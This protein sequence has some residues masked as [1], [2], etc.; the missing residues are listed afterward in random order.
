MI[1]LERLLDL[2]WPPIVFDQVL[3]YIFVFEIVSPILYAVDAKKQ[4]GS[5]IFS[6]YHYPRDS[7]DE[8]HHGAWA[9]IPDQ[10]GINRADAPILI[11]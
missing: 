3:L 6:V 9:K 5:T 7:N 11:R 4:P 2:N 8:G 1:L 10:D